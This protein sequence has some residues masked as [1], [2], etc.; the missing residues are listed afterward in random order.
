LRDYAV[1]VSGVSVAGAS[2]GV[3]SGVEV[4]SSVVVSS[5]INIL[6]VSSAKCDCAS[7]YYFRSIA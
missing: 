3:S 1:G 5:D 2:T 7:I 4:V 6:R